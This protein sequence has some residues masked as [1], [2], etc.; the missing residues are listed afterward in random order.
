MDSNEVCFIHFTS[1]VVHNFSN[2]VGVKD[3]STMQEK[4]QDS[5]PKRE[6][7]NPRNSGLSSQQKMVVH[8]LR[9]VWKNSYAKHEVTGTTCN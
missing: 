9:T 6:G 1:G 4:I 8:Y 2:A 3:L 5:Y 7:G